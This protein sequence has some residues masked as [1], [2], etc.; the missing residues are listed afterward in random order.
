M[1]A[2]NQQNEQNGTNGE[3]LKYLVD[4]LRKKT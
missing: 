2:L 4:I 3:G 1:E